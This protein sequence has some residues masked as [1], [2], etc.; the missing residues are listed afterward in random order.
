MASAAGPQLLMSCFSHS[1][2]GSE[3]AGGRGVGDSV[4]VGE[5]AEVGSRVMVGLGDGVLVSSIEGIGA[6]WVCGMGEGSG[7]TGSTRL[8]TYASA[9]STLQDSRS[10]TGGIQYMASVRT[11][12]KDSSKN[13]P[14]E[15]RMAAIVTSL[16]EMKNR[17]GL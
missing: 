8:R 6:V 4:G 17:T 15:I 11:A 13:T 7:S 14:F 10:W 16:Y 1:G 12:A 2:E 3:A 9:K 5:A